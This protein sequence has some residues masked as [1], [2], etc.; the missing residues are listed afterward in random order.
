VVHPAN[1]KADPLEIGHT[2]SLN[3]GSKDGGRGET[4]HEPGAP[5]DEI[6]G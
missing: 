3:Y 1:Q 2:S 4:V 5:G 6:L